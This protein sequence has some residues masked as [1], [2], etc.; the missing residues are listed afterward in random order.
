VSDDG[1]AIVGMAARLPGASDV[2]A[3]WD[4]LCAGIDTMHRYSAAELRAAGVGDD[5]LADPR[6]VRAGGYLPGIED[7]DAEFFG[8]TPAE[9]AEIDPQHR[10]FL[11][12]AWHALQDAGEQPGRLEGPVGVFTGT[13]VNRYFLRHLYR[14]ELLGAADEP[15]PPGHAPDYLPLR[16]A[17]KLGLT[18][19]AVATQAACAS[20]LV[21]VCLA[22]QS[23]LDF[24][25]DLAIAGGSSVAATTP[26]GYLA[27]AG[28]SPDGTIRAFDAKAQGTRYA[29]GAAGVVLKRCE[30][31]TDD[32]VYAVLRGWAVSNDGARRG[33]FAVPGVAG[34]ADAVAEALAT[35]DLSPADIGYVEAHGS[36]T[37]LGDAIEVRAL[38]S[39]FAGA[40]QPCLL[41][42]VKP[43]I[44]NLDAAAGVAGL[45]KAA[46]AV[47]D[48][49]VPASLHFDAPHPDVD[50]SAGRFEIAAGTREW[51]TPGPRYAGVSAIGLGGTTAHVVLGE[52]APADA[53]RR[54]PL[55]PQRFHRQRHWIEPVRRQ[56]DGTAG[57]I[58]TQRDRAATGTEPRSEVDDD[59]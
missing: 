17:Y 24:R 18:G 54:A 19:P 55:P 8:Y 26:S 39:V 53:P 42:S 20:S 56:R 48:G 51:P 2:A 40:A 21:A 4:N 58:D 22:A 59:R 52:P 14:P 46:L 36:G 9:A 34:L 50:L 32:R 13:S 57:G 1:I 28:L 44:G 31:V 29:S 37:P 30:D 27:R 49:V 45:I 11:E 10:L 12:V 6:Y 25:C 7:F 15:M 38:G 43:S 35:A 33:G 3:Y 47:R 41:G 23:L 16:T 5:L